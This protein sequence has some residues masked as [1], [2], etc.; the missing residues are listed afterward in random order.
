MAKQIKVSRVF[1]A[2]VERVWNLWTDP[3]KRWWG[4]GQFTA[5]IVNV[6]F[7]V[8]LKSIVSM[9]APEVMGARE[10][11]S[12]WEYAEILPLKKIEFVQSLCDKEGNKIDPTKAGMPSDFPTDIQTIV[13][14]T[15]LANGTTEMTITEFADFGSISNFAQMGLE[16]SMDKM[17]EI[18]L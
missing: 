16:Q 7:G 10:F 5:R 3:E 12:V 6:K 4:P 2:P 14:F 17:I 8:G 18:S 11:Y 9:V 15:L 13:A 1:N